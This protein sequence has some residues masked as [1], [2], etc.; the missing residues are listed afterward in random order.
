MK[1]FT[2]NILDDK[3]GRGRG[4]M[5]IWAWFLIV[6]GAIVVIMFLI[7]TIPQKERP[8]G[9]GTGDGVVDLS[10][11]PS[12]LTWSGSVDVQNIFNTSGAETYDTTAYFYKA[13]TE[14][15]KTS[16]T[17]TTAGAVT[18]TCGKSYDVKVLSVSGAAGD[19]SR[20]RTSSHGT[21]SDEGVVTFMATGDGERLTFGMH[22]QG[23]IE[24]RVF[25]LIND[26]F[27]FANGEASATAYI[28]TD[29]ANWTNTNTDDAPTVVGT[30]GE[31]HQKLFVRATV[32]D[33]N[34]NDLGTYVLIDAS[35]TVWDT[36]TVRIDGAIAT[37]IISTGLN[38]D[39]V[40]AYSTYEYAYLIDK[41]NNIVNNKEII[42]D[43]S[44]FA[45]AGTDPTEADDIAIDHATIGR[46]SSITGANVL[47][48]GS[49]DDSSLRT[50]VYA[51]H[52]A[53]FAVS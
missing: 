48:V 16:I 53:D 30:A 39:E 23:V 8:I 31:W 29:G 19:Q 35:T 11:C 37:D 13:G 40:K 28:S 49:V 38:P 47:K 52:D 25:D 22:Q 24:M 4:R 21:V 5:P 17:D 3:F 2:K 15:L 46:Y 34:V 7:G 10:A 20:I 14:D 33:Q 45:L 36:P 18:L 50:S 26:G 1:I 9:D 43:V 44:I 42:V 41:S 27:V 12:D 51:L 32:T 6:I